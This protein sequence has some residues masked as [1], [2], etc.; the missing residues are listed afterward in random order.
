MER[1]VSARLVFTTTNNTKIALAVAAA[2]NP[3]FSAFQE[4]LTVRSQ[5]NDIPVEEIADHH[6]GRL[7]YFDTPQPSTVT[8]EY[9]ATIR[10]RATAEV[11]A[12][13]DLIRYV[14]PSRYAESDRLLPTAYAEFGSLQGAELLNAVRAWVNTELRYVSG[15]SRGTDGAVETLLN[16]RGVC[17]DYAHLAIALLRSKD[18]PA[19]LAA[20][21]A[22]GLS[23]M[24]FHAVAEAFV[25]GAW[26][27]IDPT[28]LAPRE[29][30]VRITAGRDAA[31]TAFLSTVG[32][33]LVLNEMVVGAV[34]NGNLP[35]EEPES[36]VVLG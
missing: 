15:S 11:P 31:D 29:S 5:G 1:T 18:I 23:P 21:Y 12:P 8:V 13:V 25:E 2:R 3:G 34:V 7:H 16:R 9:S 26:H 20:V 17:R 10:G 4:S 22:P 36:L 28:A 14:R 30:M 32:G 33:S 35:L 6:G 27:V 19:R 24:D